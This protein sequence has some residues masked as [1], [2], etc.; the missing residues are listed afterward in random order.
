ML[1]KSALGLSKAW[2]ARLCDCESEIFPLTIGDD[3]SHAQQAD[4][5][6]SCNAMQV[7][8]CYSKAREHLSALSINIKSTVN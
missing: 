7:P 6:I 5:A 3:R 2:A 4:S 8:F 1:F